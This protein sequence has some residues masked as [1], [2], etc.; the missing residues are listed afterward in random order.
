MLHS[1][2][3]FLAL[4]AVLAI[5]S[6]ACS[7]DSSSSSAA[8]S[9][10]TSPADDGGSAI[11][12]TEKDFSIG[13]DP[14]EVAAGEVTFTI[15]NEGPSA[16]EFVVVQTD[17]APGDLPVKDGLVEEDGITVVDEAEDIAP[18]TTTTLT[19][20]DLEAG[21]YVIICNLPGHYQQG[22]NVGLTV[23]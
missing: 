10:A 3:A 14:T 12:A 18:S 9:T 20:D 5:A 4:V 7:S 11:A 15:N 8:G 2:R 13:I 1:R 16:H 19:I 17:L 23:T 21:S 22:M 6:V